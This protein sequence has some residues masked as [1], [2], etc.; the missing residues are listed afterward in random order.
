[1]FHNNYYSFVATQFGLGG[2]GLRPQF[3]SGATMGTGISP[4]RMTSPTGIGDG[5]YMKI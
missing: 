1:M 2:I 3:G 5:R 4:Q